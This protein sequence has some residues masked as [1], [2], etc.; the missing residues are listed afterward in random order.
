M[1]IRAS[2]QSLCRLCAGLILTQLSFS[3]LSAEFT[4]KVI[5]KEPPAQLDASIRKALQPKAVQLIEGEKAAFEFWFAS[6]VPLIQ[7]PESPQK[8]LEAIKQTTLLG[9]VAVL[10]SKRD[11]KDNDYPTGIYTMRFA[12][13]PQD[14]NHLGS[15]EFPYFAVLVQ[16]KNDSK[17]DA[18]PDY[19]TLVKASSKETATDHPIVLSLRPVSASDGETPK[20]NEPVSEHKSLRVSLPATANSEKTNI[21]FE[22]VFQGVGHI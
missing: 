5:D 9:A 4:I 22:L 2:I 1:H 17:L 14:G 7:K 15:A 6:E 21:V 12:L 13:Q 3:A 8:A 10:V 18:F 11:Y 20:I 19:K 16:A